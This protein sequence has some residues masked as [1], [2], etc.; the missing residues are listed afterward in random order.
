MSEHLLRQLYN[1]PAQVGKMN[2]GR[3]VRVSAALDVIICS[4]SLGFENES[5]FTR[6]FLLPHTEQS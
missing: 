4:A 3:S 5:L 1:Y 6:L 2:K